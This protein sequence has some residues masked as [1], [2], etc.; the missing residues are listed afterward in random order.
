MARQWP[1]YPLWQLLPESSCS[2]GNRLRT[3]WAEKWRLAGKP[4]AV[5]L[6]LHGA[7]RPLVEDA[8]EAIDCCTGYR[9]A[10]QRVAG[11][12][13]KVPLYTRQTRRASQLWS[14]EMTP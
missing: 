8:A 10:P 13:R 4:F 11:G 12:R 3:E 2:Q 7:G 9:S 5:D 14:K 1:G 6:P